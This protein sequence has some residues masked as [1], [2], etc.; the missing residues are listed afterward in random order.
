MCGVLPSKTKIIHTGQKLAFLFKCTQ[1]NSYEESY[2][3][4]HMFFKEK[5]YSQWLG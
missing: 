2:P 3:N 4:S 5:S 1:T